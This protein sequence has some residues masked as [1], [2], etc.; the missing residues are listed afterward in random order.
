[1]MHPKLF[2][3]FVAVVFGCLSVRAQTQTV[4]QD[5][6]DTGIAADTVPKGKNLIH[7]NVVSMLFREPELHYERLFYNGRIGLKP[8]FSYFLF[9]HEDIRGRRTRNY[10][11]GVAAHVY[12]VEAPGFKFFMGAGVEVGFYTNERIIVNPPAAVPFDLTQRNERYTFYYGK[13]GV[14]LEP[15]RYYNLGLNL[16]LG[17]RQNRR[18][19]NRDNFVHPTVEMMSIFRF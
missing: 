7:F 18:L 9:D 17:S 13:M 12:L 10:C 8:Y 16:N 19:T 2:L 3:F 15:F 1:M 14:L 4:Q 11:G 6:N 5:K